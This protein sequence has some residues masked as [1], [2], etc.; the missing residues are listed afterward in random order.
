MLRN[1]GKLMMVAVL[2]SS[3]AA[4][5]APLALWVGQT[6]FLGFPSRGSRV[7][8]SNEEVIEVQKTK[9]GM[10]IRAKRPGVSQVKLRLR[11]GEQHEFA[12]HVTPS[13]AEVYSVSR[14]ESEHAPF[15]LSPAPVE[16]KRGTAQAQG[17]EEDK[18]GKSDVKTAE[19][20]VKAA[21]PRA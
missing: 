9:S 13:G 20:G 2:L 15:S 6:T 14:A 3:T 5:A 17:P 12:V 19:H 1:T 21:R 4:W 7:E 18:A 11:D 8:V 10:E 16:D